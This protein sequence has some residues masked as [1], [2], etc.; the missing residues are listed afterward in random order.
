MHCVRLAV[1]ENR[2]VVSIIS[3]DDY[4]KHLEELGRG[5]VVE[6][7]EAPSESSRAEALV[8]NRGQLDPRPAAAKRKAT[9]R[10]VA[11][12]RGRR[13]A[14]G[15][16]PRAHQHLRAAAACRV[17]AHASGVHPRQRAQLARLIARLE[18]EVVALV[19]IT[20][21]RAFFGPGVALGAAPKPVLIG[22]VRVFV[23]PT[24]SGLNA[25][26]PGFEDKL[27]CGSAG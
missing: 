1:H 23:V 3:E 13:E 20:V 4:R 5:W 21:Y 12:L 7:A 14:A 15:V 10:Q 2:L 27:V 11:H 18:P 9:R 8:P 16:R 19:G 24:P 22:T 6:G 26:Y 25:A 17:R